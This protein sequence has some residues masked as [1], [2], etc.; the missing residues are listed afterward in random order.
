MNNYLEDAKVQKDRWMIL[1]AVGLFT[2]MSTLDGSIV[3]IALPTM[4]KEMHIPANQAEW[5]VSIYLMVVCS[6]L[7]LFGKIG[8]SYGKIKVFRIGTFIFVFGS[9][10]CGLNLGLPFLLGARSL[11][12]LG[13]SMTMSTNNGIITEI[14]PL[15][16]RGKA[17]GFIGSFVSLGSIAGPGIGGILLAHLG[18]SYIFW[19]NVPIGLLTILLGKFVLPKDFSMDRMKIDYKGFLL[20]TLFIFSFFAAIFI[21]QEIG[22]GKPVILGLFALALVSIAAFIRLELKLPNPL[23]SLRLFKNMDFSVSLFTAFLI[24]VVMFFFNVIAPF[25]LQNAR[26][27]AP[28]TAGYI[29]MVF[30]I[31]QVFVAPIAGGVSDKIGPELLTLLGLLLMSAGQLGFVITQEHT[32]LWIFMIF[33]ALMGIGNGMFQ[34][35]NNTIVMSTVEKQDLGIAGGLN[36]LARNFGMVSGISLATTALF[37][38]MSQVYGKHTTTYIDHRPD[39]FMSG[40]HYTFGIALAL[41]AAALLLTGWRMWKIQQLRK[42]SFLK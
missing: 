38:R 10:L 27:L 14:F 34:A 23:L 2:F 24:F 22:F 4:I 8:D 41:C 32:P 11:Q 21:G 12:A 25:Y 20:F 37:H 17:L 36:A 16:D 13:A 40:M 30:P 5:I 42:Q 26:G 3:N 1:L 39:V 19:I 15:S 35:P 28:N 6:L 18:W 29:L 9:F 31:L 7:L 33:I